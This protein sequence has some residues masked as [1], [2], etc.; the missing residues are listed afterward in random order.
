MR[1]T[2]VLIEGFADAII[3]Y[4]QFAS[5]GSQ[6]QEDVIDPTVDAMNL[7]P[8]DIG[9]LVRPE[10]SISSA[11]VAHVLKKLLEE[12]FNYSL[13]PRHTFRRGSRG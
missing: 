7:N 5:E 12:A 6:T 11:H 4:S 8:D 10:C 2:T 13:I 9:L 1:C 3:A